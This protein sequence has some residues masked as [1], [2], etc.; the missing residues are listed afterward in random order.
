M[1]E[2]GNFQPAAGMD[3]Q[4]AASAIQAQGEAAMQQK[5]EP[6]LPKSSLG[7]D[8]PI[9]QADA[10]GKLRAGTRHH[11]RAIGFQTSGMDPQTAKEFERKA[12]RDFDQFGEYPGMDDPHAPAP[13][14]RPGKHSF[15]PMTGQFVEPEGAVSVLDR[16]APAGAKGPDTVLTSDAVRRGEV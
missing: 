16:M 12:V 3:P 14:V 4:Q 7:A 9:E 5:P 11:M 2:S 1:D 6:A 10:G 13:P 8:S 15:N